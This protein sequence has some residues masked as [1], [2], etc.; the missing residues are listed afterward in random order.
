MSLKALMGVKY[1]NGNKVKHT[2]RYS[3][4]NSKEFI[5]VDQNFSTLTFKLQSEPIRE[6]GVDGC[7]V[8]DVIEIA[9]ILVANLPGKGHKTTVMATVRLGEAIGFLEQYRAERVDEG[10]EGTDIDE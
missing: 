9:R 3:K 1:I 4:A 8:E 2:S 10:K 6:I 7:N 5:K